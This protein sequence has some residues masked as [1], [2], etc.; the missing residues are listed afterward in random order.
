MG[1]GEVQAV[2]MNNLRGLLG[3]RRVDKVPNAWIR[4]MRTDKSIDEHLHQ[5]FNHVKRMENDRDC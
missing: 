5:C 3:I 1:G 4:A 2:Q